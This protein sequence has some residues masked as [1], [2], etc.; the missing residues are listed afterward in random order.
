MHRNAQAVTDAARTLGLAI[1]VVEFPAEGARTA[2]DAAAAIGVAEGQIV[3]SLVFAVGDPSDASSGRPVVALVCGDDQLDVKRLAAAAG[4]RRAWR[5]DAKGVREATGFPVGGIPPF[6]HATTLQT[7]ADARLRRFST[8]W[9][10]AGTPSHVFEVGVEPLV[11]STGAT[12]AELAV[13]TT[14]ES[15][16]SAETAG[17]APLSETHPRPVG[18]D[19]LGTVPLTARPPQLSALPSV[20]ARVV[21]FVA[22]LLGGGL[23]GLLTY[24]VMKVWTGRSSGTSIGVWLIIGAVGCAFGVGVLATLVLRAMSEWRSLNR[25]QEMP[26]VLGG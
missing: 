20:T 3:K 26:T 11:T 5:M 15:A 10:A 13:V 23:G 25:S 17:P 7:F 9:A 24:G 16:S 21:A 12:W 8:V 2:A 14:A 6:G 22:I 19:V 18:R 4:E 1:D